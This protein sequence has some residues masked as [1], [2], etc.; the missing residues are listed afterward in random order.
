[1]NVKT[2]IISVQ[3]G[4][5][6]HFLLTDGCPGKKG[7]YLFHILLMYSFLFF[8]KSR[9]GIYLFLGTTGV[10]LLIIRAKKTNTIPPVHELGTPKYEPKP[11]YLISF[12][13]GKWGLIGNSLF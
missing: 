1:M 7:S 8:L 13:C 5:C 10:H 6:N 2:R 3:V 9:T 11:R 4:C 12:S